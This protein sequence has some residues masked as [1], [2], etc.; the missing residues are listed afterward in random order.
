MSDYEARR[1][2]IE[3]DIADGV[4]S[5]EQLDDWATGASKGHRNSVDTLRPLDPAVRPLVIR[6]ANA[7]MNTTPG[8]NFSASV[9]QAAKSVRAGRTPGLDRA[10]EW[11]ARG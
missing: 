1:T 5:D 3:R 9:W 8:W 6:E 4:I 11:N 7:W 10:A 2:V